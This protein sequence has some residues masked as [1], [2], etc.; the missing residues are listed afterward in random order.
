MRAPTLF[1]FFFLR[2]TFPDTFPSPMKDISV[3]QLPP[4]L[5]LFWEA[6][7]KYFLSVFRNGRK[8]NEELNEPAVPF[9][10]QI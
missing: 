4:L 5:Q 10:V 9:V 2:V 1:S 7:L 6:V 3:S 8:N